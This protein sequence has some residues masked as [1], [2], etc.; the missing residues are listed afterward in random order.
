MPAICLI[1]I[2]GN[3]APSANTFMNKRTERLRGDITCLAQWPCLSPGVCGHLAGAVG[4]DDQDAAARQ[5]PGQ[6]EE[7]AERG[8]IH[9]LHVVEQQ[10]EGLL[11]CQGVQ[12][13]RH[14]LEQGNR[15]QCSFLPGLCLLCQ[16][17]EPGTLQ[18]AAGY[19]RLA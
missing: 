4:A 13:A 1:Q 5:P 16:S 3:V 11:P 10:D 14:L 9:P 19:E 6:V 12:H 15:L 17:V 8:A 7:Q 2:H 18:K